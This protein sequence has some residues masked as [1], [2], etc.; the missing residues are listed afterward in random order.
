MGSKKPPLESL[1]TSN[2]PN[3]S[4]NNGYETGV[5]FGGDAVDSCQTA[6]ETQV[7]D[8]NPNGTPD[9]RNN[10][11]MSLR[12]SWSDPNNDG[13]SEAFKITLLNAVYDNSKFLV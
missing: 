4:L 10:I 8:K 13:A 7:F 6:L 12:E 3:R 9:T 1:P 11:L 5:I 2:E